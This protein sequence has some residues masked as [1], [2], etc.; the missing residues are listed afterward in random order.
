[1]KPFYVFLLSLC[2]ITAAAQDTGYFNYA[3]KP[4]IPQLAS[5]YQMMLHTDSGWTFAIHWM[6]NRLKI[7][8]RISDDMKRKL[9]TFTYYD[10]AGTVVQRR[11][12]VGYG[13]AI[14]SDYF[15]DGHLMAQGPTL[16]EKKSGEWIGYYPSGTIKAPRPLSMASWILPVF[17]MKMGLPTTT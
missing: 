11:K 14:E 4:T 8:G 16:E 13:G 17:S 2:G 7:T 15:P 9:G 6:N 12:Y 1:M 3:D 5:Y 10:T